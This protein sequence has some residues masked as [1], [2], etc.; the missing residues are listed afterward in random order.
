VNARRPRDEIAVVW[1]YATAAVAGLAMATQLVNNIVEAPG[2]G[3]APDPDAYGSALQRAITYLSFFTTQSNILILIGAL[4]L[5]RRPQRSETWVAWVRLS[6]LV[7]ITITFVVN[8]V[9]L[10]PITADLYSGIWVATDFLLHYLTPA[11][12]VVGWLLFG[13]RPR[14]GHR[15]LA[16]FLLWPGAWLAYTFVRGA[17]IDWYPYPF[18]DVSKLGYV[19]AF[20]TT[21]VVLIIGLGLALAFIAL[22][23]RLAAPP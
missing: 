18:L 21:A 7:G 22:D 14:F 11:L 10:R 2:R 4:A 17:I 15:A 13:P 3:F 5:A 12:A 8:L 19:Q 9:V 23:R 16:R 1:H 6:G 20:A